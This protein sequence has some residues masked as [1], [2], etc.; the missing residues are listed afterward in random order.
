M[1]RSIMTLA[2]I[3]MT[4]LQIMA[5]PAANPET[6]RKI[7]FKVARKAQNLVHK[8]TANFEKI[9]KECEE[10]RRKATENADAAD[11]KRNSIT[12]DTL[13]KEEAAKLAL[14]NAVI[15]AEQAHRE[16]LELQ[17]NAINEL[18]VPMTSKMTSKL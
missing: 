13:R 1:K 5:E 11:A 3:A 16:V 10:D 8:L 18:K 7:A 15:A 2:L 6:Q 9:K 17:K 4:S 14:N 12:E